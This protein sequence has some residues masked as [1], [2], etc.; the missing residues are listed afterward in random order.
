MKELMPDVHK[1]FHHFTGI[2]G[3]G[4]KVGPLLV[5][6]GVIIPISRVVTPVKPNYFRPFIGV[7][8]TTQFNLYL[9]TGHT[10]WWVW[11]VVSST[12]GCVDLHPG[13]SGFLP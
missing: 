8:Y 7:I 4:C 12:L 3:F 13:I 10:L 2:L 6:N 5:I 11:L 1:T 9:V